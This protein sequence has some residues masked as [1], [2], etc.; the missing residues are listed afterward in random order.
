LIQRFPQTEKDSITTKNVLRQRPLLVVPEKNLSNDRTQP[1][2]RY[3]VCSRLAISE[4]E[5]TA[6]LD[7][8]KK[9]HHALMVEYVNILNRVSKLHLFVDFQ[10]AFPL[11]NDKLISLARLL[12]K[13]LTLTFLVRL[14][15]ESHIKGKLR[16]LNTSYVHLELATDEPPPSKYQ[17]WRKQ[18]EEASAGF[19]DTLSHSPLFRIITTLWLLVSGI[20]F[21]ILGKILELFS[22]ADAAKV[23]VSSENVTQIVNNISL[24]FRQS[25]ISVFYQDAYHSYANNFEDFAKMLFF[26]A[27]VLICISLAFA[28]KRSLF[29]PGSGFLWFDYAG[30]ERAITVKNVYEMEDDLFN[31]LEKGKNREFPMDLVTFAL[32][33]FIFGGFCVFIPFFPTWHYYF[34][35]FFGDVGFYIYL[36]VPLFFWIIGFYSLYKI[37]SRGRLRYAA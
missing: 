20:G 1:I 23:A 31:L 9:A 36:F 32:F 25:N 16:E 30:K 33:G 3:M 10:V 21:T 14:F 13:Y 34:F 27:Y 8:I 6:Q 4:G 26:A 19:V 2:R 11:K 7:D 5:V 28:Y 15:V 35:N 37:L 18:T 17:E 24:Q 29:L 22:T 12:I